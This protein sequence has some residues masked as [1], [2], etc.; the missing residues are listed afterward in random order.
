[1]ASAVNGECIVGELGVSAI[2]YACVLGGAVLGFRLQAIL[3]PQH[4]NE[5]TRQ[6]VTVAIGLI[7]TLSALVL[8]LL[9]ASAKSSFDSRIS[10][11]RQS[12]TRIVMLDRNLRLYGP[13]AKPARAL[14]QKLTQ[15][16]IDRAW[17]LGTRDDRVADNTE[18]GNLEELQARLWALAPTDP[19]HQWRQ[20]RALGLLSELERAHWALFE[21]TGSSIPTPFMVVLVLWLT[22]I[23]M[24]LG[25]FAPRNRTVYGMMFVC[26]L[27]VSTAIFLIMEMDQPFEGVVQIS[28]APLRKALDELQ[29]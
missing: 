9:V 3:P 15:Q 1:V 20:T 28:D 14:L 8:G 17:M 11:V 10:D 4:V 27:S 24:S 29:Q 7:A 5:Q 23:F 2:V 25:L 21:Q 6:T 26:A 19:V 12:A 18:T 22:V 13:E 16:R